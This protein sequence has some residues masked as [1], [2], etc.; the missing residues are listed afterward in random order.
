METELESILKSNEVN[1]IEVQKTVAE[2]G[3]V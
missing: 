1:I 3:W 2:I